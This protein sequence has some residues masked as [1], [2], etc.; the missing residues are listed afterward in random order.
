MKISENQAV[1]YLTGLALAMRKKIEIF[2]SNNSDNTDNPI[3][4]GDLFITPE[5]RLMCGCLESIIIKA[6]SNILFNVEEQKEKNH[7]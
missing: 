1:E 4:I 7:E 2:D 6:K 3:G 5:E